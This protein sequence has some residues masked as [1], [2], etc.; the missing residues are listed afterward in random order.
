[1]KNEIDRRN[2]ITTGAVGAGAAVM[3]GCAAFDRVGYSMILGD[4][5]GKGA[6]ELPPLQKG[7]GAGIDEAWFQN[8]IK[9]FIKNDP[10]NQ[11]GGKHG[12]EPI[13]KEPLIGFASGADSLFEEYKK[14]IGPFH[15][16]PEEAIEWASNQQGISAPSIK[17]VS[18]V[19]FVMPLADKIVLDNAAQDRW[20][21][22]R[23]A[24]GRYS[25]GLL[26]KKLMRDLVSDLAEHGVL[27]VAPEA[28]PQYRIKNHDSVGWASHWSQRH[29]AF[30]AGLGSFGMN[31]FFISEKGTAHRCCSIVVALP[32]EPNRERHPHY[33][34]NCLHHQT[35]G[36]LICA[37]RCPVGANSENGHDKDKCGNNVFRNVP[38]NQV[39]NEINIYGCGLCGS[40]TPC[41]QEAPI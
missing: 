4:A 33:R 34:H 31:D 7:D 19:S 17:Q 40:G 23:W 24:H 20:C 26:G 37:E 30:A 13:F 3:S 27:A 32:L 10:S 28:M 38:R 6:M 25:G 2:F 15:F 22:S 14:I 12:S 41:A 8:Y 39:I 36:C 21:S 18:V 1:M 5:M 16:T 11:L 9:D 35:G 29:I